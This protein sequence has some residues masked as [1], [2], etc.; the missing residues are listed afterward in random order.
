MFSVD[1]GHGDIARLLLNRGANPDHINN[2]GQTSAD[3][4]ATASKLALQEIIES[5]SEEK[6]RACGQ[7]MRKNGNIEQLSEMESV[8]KNA[9]LGHLIQAFHEH[10]IDLESFLVLRESEINVLV[11][12]VIGDGKKLINLQV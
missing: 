3:I 2:N 12:G 6:G 10:N 4:A 11:S 7:E 5:F 8:L 1:S 9:S